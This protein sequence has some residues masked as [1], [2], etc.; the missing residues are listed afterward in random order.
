MTTNSV[1]FTFNDIPVRISDHPKESKGVDILIKW[2]T[3]SS[4]I[5]EQ[6]KTLIQ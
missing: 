6:L 2:D 4:E 5:I 1:Y 3:Q